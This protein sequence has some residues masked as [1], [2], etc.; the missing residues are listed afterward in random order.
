MGEVCLVFCRSGT[1]DLEAAERSLLG[2]GLTVTRK[3]DTLIA[4][5]PGSPQ[6]R[7]HLVVGELVRAEATEIGKGTP[8]EAAMRECD[9]RF[10]IGIDDLDEALDEFN[11]L[12]EV[13]GALQDA[14][15]GYLFLPWNGN[16][17]E[18]WHD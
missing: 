3:D 17:S 9:A 1:C 18:P 12:M 14:S 16:L 4:G 13:Q 10:E 5:W 7:V 8:Y 11:T 2:Y 6:F 15:Q